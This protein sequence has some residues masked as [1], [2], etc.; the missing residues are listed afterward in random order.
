M[1]AAELLF[2]NATIVDGTG[3]APYRGNVAVGA[4]RILAVGDYDG[5]AQRE[6]DA[7]GRVV[8]PGFIDIHTHFD[9][10]LCWDKLATPSLE[11]G[12]TTVV[13]GNCSLSLA[14]IRP[15]GIDQVVTMFPVIV[16]LDNR[17]GLLRPGMNA[18][19]TVLVDQALDVV[20]VPNT[21][22]VQTSDVGPAAMAL[23]LDLESIDLGGA[24]GFVGASFRF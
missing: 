21:A 11:H 2:K 5:A 16:K 23:G 24:W 12:V 1:P 4:G 8:A 18:E 22:I 7:E 3:A 19:V 15:D 17:R 9:P 13:I 14:P 10:Q 6:I 20:L